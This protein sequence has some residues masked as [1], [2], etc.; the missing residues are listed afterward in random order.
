MPSSY[1]PKICEGCE[2]EVEF[3]CTVYRNPWL[4]FANYTGGPCPL[5]PPKVEASKKRVR[6][7]Q[8]KTKRLGG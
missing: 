4:T 7:G 8:Q 2:K 1:D 3:E 5:N 6:V